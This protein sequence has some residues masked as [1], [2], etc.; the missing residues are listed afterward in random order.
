MSQRVAVLGAGIAGLTA[1]RELRRNG[2]EVKVYEAG[3]RV[4]GLA[5]SHRTE[6]GFSYDT[7]AHFITNRLAREVGVEAECRV[8]RHYG[9]AV[10]LDG[11]SS[12]YP[13]GLIR[14][15]HYVLSALAARARRGS[16]AATAADWFRAEY[17]AALADE[18]ALPLVEAWSGA[19][20]DELSAAVGAKLPGGIAETIYLKV[21]AKLSRRA[22]AIG[23]C[24]EQPQSRHVWHVYP[25]RGVSTLCERLAAELGDTIQLESPVERIHVEGDRVVGLRAGG[26]DIDATAVISTAP[27]NV[28]PRLVEGTDALDEYRD[29]R[30]RPMIFVNLKLE[31]RDL[32]PDVVTWLPGDGQL[33]F[34]LTEAPQSM[35]WLAPPGRTLITVDFGAQVGDAHWSMD[36]DALAELALDDVAAVVPDVRSRFLGAGVVKTPIAYPVFLNRYE[37]ARQRLESGTGVEGLM[38]IGRNGEFAHILMEDV[39]WRTLRRV[40]GWLA[41]GSAV[42]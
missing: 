21:A 7:G 4:S 22:V 25:E 13:F 10:W 39:Y 1:A 15:P 37:P 28:L 5:T 23:Y 33:S 27:V 19:P 8:V 11:R 9:E 29:F 17:G 18:V 16:D 34:R 30:Y 35:P 36:D 24:N 31:G 38:S 42:R 41:A 6:D 3:Q 2:V 40:R 14:R 32:L 12:S 20:A 26:V